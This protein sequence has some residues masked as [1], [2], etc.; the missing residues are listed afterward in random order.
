MSPP[1]PPRWHWYWYWWYCHTNNT[2]LCINRLY[3]S[4]QQ[5]KH[6]YCLFCN[7]VPVDGMTLHKHVKATVIA[8]VENRRFPCGPT[9]VL[10]L[11][12]YF[13]TVAPIAQIVQ[14]IWIALAGQLAQSGQQQR[15]TASVGRGNQC[16]IIPIALPYHCWQQKNVRTFQQGFFALITICFNRNCFDIART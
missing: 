7:I 11:R 14:P 15:N 4:L 1:Q 2:S 6:T 9:Q 3:K 5:C 13:F 16:H 8:S 10:G 12:L